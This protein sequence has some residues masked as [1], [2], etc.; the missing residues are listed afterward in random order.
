MV[1][2]GKYAYCDTW[3]LWELVDRIGAERGEVISLGSFFNDRRRAPDRPESAV[4][5]AREIEDAR[6]YSQVGGEPREH[7]A[8]AGCVLRTSPADGSLDYEC[9]VDQRCITPDEADA[10]LLDIESILVAAAVAPAGAVV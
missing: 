8:G 9:E 1:E 6:A 7:L 5:T 2:A 10:L 4:P 3:A